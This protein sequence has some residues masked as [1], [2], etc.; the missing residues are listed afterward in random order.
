METHR[1]L[2]S[3]PALSD[4]GAGFVVYF[5]PNGGD[6]TVWIVP[7]PEYPAPDVG[8]IIDAMRSVL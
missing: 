8:A 2:P 6:R 5:P 1:F 4:Y 7:A 3:P